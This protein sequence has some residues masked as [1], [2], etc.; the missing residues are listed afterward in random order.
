[1]TNAE[2]LIDLIKDNL[3]SRLLAS[4]ELRRSGRG[5]DKEGKVII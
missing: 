3:D 5:N 2:F 4:L 1:M